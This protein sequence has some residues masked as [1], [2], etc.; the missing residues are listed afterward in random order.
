MAAEE[1]TKAFLD[2]LSLGVPV[3]MGPMRP[4][5][6]PAIP[7]KAI[8]VLESGG[9]APSTYCDGTRTSYRWMKVQARVRGEPNAYQTT[10][11]LANTVWSAFQQAPS[12]MTGSYVRVTCDQ[13]L[14]LYMGRDAYQC[15]EFS[16]NVTLEKRLA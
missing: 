5:E 3:F 4:A 13:S 11:D 14:P 16:V 1:D 6:I 2:S 10:R 7:E 9:F 8:F 12:T 15:H